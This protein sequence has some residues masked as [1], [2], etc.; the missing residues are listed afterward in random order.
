MMTFGFTSGSLLALSVKFLWNVRCHI[1]FRHGK[2]YWKWKLLPV[3][4]IYWYWY[5]WHL[6]NKHFTFLTLILREISKKVKKYF[7]VELCIWKITKYTYPNFRS[8]FFWMIFPSVW[9]STKMALEIFRGNPV[10]ST[11]TV[12]PLLNVMVRFTPSGVVC[13]KIPMKTMAKTCVLGAYFYNCRKRIFSFH[14]ASRTCAVFCFF[15]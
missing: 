3:I 9:Y 5:Y 13:T 12:I 7:T 2:V 6:V 1:H 4:I 14:C 10:G 15:N 11:F 8:W